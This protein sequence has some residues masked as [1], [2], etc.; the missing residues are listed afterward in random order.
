[1][2]DVGNLIQA[3]QTPLATIQAI[4]PIYAEFDLSENDWLRF[5]AMQ[6]QNE[7]PDPDKNRP[8][9][10]LGLPNEDGF[11]H[12]GKL[13]FRDLQIDRATATAARRAIFPNPGWQLIP[14]MFVR[15]SAFIG[16]PRPKLLVEERS[17]GTDQRG[18]YL[19]V[20]NDKN[21][22]EYR[23]VKTGIHAG[24]LRVIEQ[25]ININDWVVINGLQRARPG[26]QV[27]PEHS[28]MTDVATEVKQPGSGKAAAETKPAPE[29]KA[30]PQKADAKAPAAKSSQK[31]EEKSSPSVKPK[32]DE[33]SKTEKASTPQ[34]TDVKVKADEKAA[35]AEPK[36][37]PA[38]EPKA[39]EQATK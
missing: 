7:L 32:A 20:V 15:I 37:P 10:Y 28:Q 18:E 27:T 5:M 31:A 38:A 21:K 24:M 39:N 36:S 22:V 1:M 12:E 25:G 9:L 2:V 6:R 34:K 30:A 13:D 11:P 8:T 14:G 23:I 33:T 4:D 3:E 35:P 19:L 26:A 29:S 17:L 16:S